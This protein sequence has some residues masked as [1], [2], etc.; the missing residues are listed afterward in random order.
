MQDRLALSGTTWLASSSHTSH[1][2]HAA[3]EITE[4]GS[5]ATTAFL[6]TFLAIL[7]VDLT[8]LGVSEDVVSL[9]ELLEDGLVATLV[10]MMLEGQLSEGFLDLI[11][12]S[13]LIYTE[14]LVI[15]FIVDLLL[16]STGSSATHLLETCAEWETTATEEHFEFNK[17][18]YY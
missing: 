17:I 2:E 12:S 4:I 10:R 7:V 5:T 6:E 3:K 18:I 16:W 15:L 14:Q 8:L 9:V 11:C 13:I 1:A